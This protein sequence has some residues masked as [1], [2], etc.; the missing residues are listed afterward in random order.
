MTMPCSPA[1]RASGA[2]PDGGPGGAVLEALRPLGAG[3][4]LPQKALAR[5]ARL[6]AG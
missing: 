2:G 1:V 5:G 3:A 4:R 6:A